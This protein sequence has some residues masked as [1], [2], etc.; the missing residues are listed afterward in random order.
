MEPEGSAQF[1]RAHDY[2]FPEQAQV[3]ILKQIQWLFS[4]LTIR[5]Q[6]FVGFS[7]SKDDYERE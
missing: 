3:C 4:R 1:K 6:L 2:S 7:A 5:V